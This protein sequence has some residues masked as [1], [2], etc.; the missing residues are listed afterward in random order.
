MKRVDTGV[1][2]GVDDVK[3]WWDKILWKMEGGAY[4]RICQR[5]MWKKDM[6]D[7]TTCCHCD[8]VLWSHEQ[9]FGKYRY[10]EV[11]ITLTLKPHPD[12]G[13]TVT[14]D[15]LPELVTEGDTIK[16]AIEM[17]GDAFET[18]VELYQDSNRMGDLPFK[19]QRLIHAN[20]TVGKADGIEIMRDR[21]TVKE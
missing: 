1:R 9:V 20:D 16:E 12:G 13:F 11:D 21:L 15:D 10:R 3:T 17:A 4:C 8:D 5:D 2:Y 19:I 18:V 6:I 7:K 14:C